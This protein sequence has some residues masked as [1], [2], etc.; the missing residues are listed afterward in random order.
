[1]SCA[2]A[3]SALWAM[4]SLGVADDDPAAAQVAQHRGRD[5]AGEG[6]VLERGHILGTPGHFGVAQPG[7]CLPQIGVRRRDRNLDLREQGAIDAGPQG[8]EKMFVGDQIAIHL[9]VADHEGFASLH[10]HG[11]FLR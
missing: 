6:T 8:G 4:V 5:L 1:M 7:R 10:A 11:G 9:P 2:R 3:R